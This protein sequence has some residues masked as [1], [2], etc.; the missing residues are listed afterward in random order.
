MGAAMGTCDCQTVLMMEGGEGAHA[1][2]TALPLRGA[3]GGTQKH[4]HSQSLVC[5]AS[6]GM[7]NQLP[8][9]TDTQTQQCFCALFWQVGARS[10]PCLRKPL[11][12]QPPARVPGAVSGQRLPAAR[13][14]GPATRNGGAGSGTGT[15][16]TCT[17]GGA[18]WMGLFWAGDSAKRKEC[19][20]V[21]EGQAPKQQMVPS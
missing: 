3:E 14:A 18:A 16:Q 2:S 20:Q 8:W 13:H 7:G 21:V 11:C 6:L 12:E 19:Y 17:G 4:R 5:T 9:Q 1:A 15:G 10:Q